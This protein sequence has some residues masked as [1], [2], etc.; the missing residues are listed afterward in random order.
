MKLK[1]VAKVIIVPF[2]ILLYFG[3]KST[4]IRKENKVA[5]ATAIHK[6]LEL[7]L[8]ND[9]IPSFYKLFD[10]SKFNPNHIEEFGT[11][12]LFTAVSKDNE[13]VCDF[14]LKKGADIN[15][16][17]DYGTVMHWALEE[18]NFKLANYLLDKGYDPKVEEGMKKNPEPL[19]FQISFLALRNKVA[20]VKLFQRLINKGMDSNLNDKEGVA[21]IHLAVYFEDLELIN[22]LCTS[23]ANI[24]LRATSTSSNPSSKKDMF[25]TNRYTPLMLA[26]HL[27]KQ[28]SVVEL[29]KCKNTNISLKSKDGKTALDIAVEKDNK[30]IIDLLIRGNKGL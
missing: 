6:Q 4:S 8:K 18:S 11:T 27:E 14:L 26:A 21:A 25:V 13:E 28:K 10:K 20:G 24:N 5:N 2:V 30:P 3:C 29:L 7:L 17:S 16:V 19:N 12:L 15:F 1:T 9:S 22:L 23:D